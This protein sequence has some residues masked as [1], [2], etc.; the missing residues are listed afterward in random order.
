MSS[1]PAVKRKRL[2]KTFKAD[3][4]QEEINEALA[5]RAEELEQQKYKEK[6]GMI[7]QI[8]VINFMCHAHLSVKFGSNIN[9]IIGS[10]GSGKSAILAALIV[11]LGG[12]TTTTSRG[13]SFKN[14]I[15]YG[16][17]SATIRITL[18]NDGDDKYESGVFGKRILVERKI[19]IDGLSTYKLKTESS[20]LISNKRED[21]IKML[22][23]LNIQVE[24]PLTCLNQE[25]SK[26]FLHTKSEADKYK[27]FLKTTQLEQIETDYNFIKEQKEKQAEFIS[28]KERA[29]P[30]LNG[31]VQEKEEAYKKLASISELRTRKEKLEGELAWSHVQEIE[32]MLVPVKEEYVRETD[33]V[34]K[35]KKA[36]KR[37]QEKEKEA[38]NQIDSIKSEVAKV[39]EDQKKILP[40]YKEAESQLK[41]SKDDYRKA[42][43]QKMQLKNEREEALKELN[44]L[45]VR[46]EEMKVLERNEKSTAAYNNAQEQLKIQRGRENELLQNIE[47]FNQKVKELEPHKRELNQQK[48]NF[49]NQYQTFEQDNVNISRELKGLQSSKK[50]KLS[51]YGSNMVNFDQHVEQA[52][53]A[54]RFKIKPLGPIGRYLSVKDKNLVFAVEQAVKGYVNSFI[55]F[56]HEDEKVLNELRS[57]HLSPFDQNR[58]SIYNFKYSENIY[59]TSTPNCQ[60]KSILNLLSI[61]DPNVANFLIDWASIEGQ[62][63]IP[64]IDNA[65]QFMNN[66]K[67]NNV[68][69]AFTIGGDQVFPGRF[70]SCFDKSK[71]P[72]YL[73]ASVEQRINDCELRIKQNNIG[74]LNIRKNL[75]EIRQ[76]IA[77]YQENV[78]SLNNDKKVS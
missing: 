26:N 19:S 67:P 32:E 49:T 14:L 27:F 55:V 60:Y 78:N 65:T 31:V 58:I 54:K 51:L 50:N 12:K 28:I 63:V 11:G 44:N 34:E 76:N 73:G 29:L 37:T 46:I 47:H 20:K 30:F 61:E 17:N 66:Q 33:R 62:L 39:K 45:Q 9:F 41:K 74:K 71:K 57:N 13:T 8:Q 77:K 15:K 59:K 25:L 42:N 22:D 38:K 75:E 35:F 70:Y 48:D 5:L 53:R 52:Y 2:E 10:N 72:R 68:F 24:N 69:K 6:F 7:D 21:I 23:Q 3:I 56:S 43:F 64:D 36:L 40:E 16:C 1:Q 18:R 4:T